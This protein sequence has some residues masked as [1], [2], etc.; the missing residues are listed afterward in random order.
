MGS[1]EDK[2]YQKQMIGKENTIAY[3][4]Q[5]PLINLN[6]LPSLKVDTLLLFS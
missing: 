3:D 6:A 1:F 4:W 5:K 2:Y